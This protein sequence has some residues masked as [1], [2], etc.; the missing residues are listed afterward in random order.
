MKLIVALGIEEHTPLLRR[1]FQEHRILI[2]SEAPIEGFRPALP[3][4]DPANWFAS[5]HEGVYSRVVFSFVED[6][7]ARELIDAIRSHNAAAQ[8]A[9]P[10]HAFALTVDFHS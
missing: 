5:R 1:I 6:A 2:Y 9:N 3:E 10:M 7:T 8:L 4:T